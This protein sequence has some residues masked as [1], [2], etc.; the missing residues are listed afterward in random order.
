MARRRGWMSNFRRRKGWPA[1]GARLGRELRRMAPNLWA[2]GIDIHFD[3]PSRQVI[4]IRKGLHSTDIT[5]MPSQTDSHTTT[6]GVDVHDSNVDGG[7]SS[8][9]ATPS[10]SSSSN[11]EVGANILPYPQS[12]LIPHGTPSR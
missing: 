2:V 11:N 8:D 6:E 5:D 7:V 9:G 1:D 3:T 12:Y 4:A 10:I